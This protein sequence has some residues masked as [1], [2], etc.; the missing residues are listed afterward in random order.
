MTN[1]S[2]KYKAEAPYPPFGYAANAER[3]AKAKGPDPDKLKP[4][5][6][7]FVKWT[8]GMTYRGIIRKKL[9]ENFSIEINDDQWHY[10]SNLASVPP[11]ALIPDNYPNYQTK[12][13][14]ETYGKN[15]I[16]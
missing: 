13:E 3:R 8:N 10:S 5:S 6:G 1:K 14:R 7:V 15:T 4:G 9:R 11:Y 16:Q 12:I 2:N